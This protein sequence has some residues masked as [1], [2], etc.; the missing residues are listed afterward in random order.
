MVAVV[1]AACITTAP[2]VEA[3]LRLPTADDLRRGAQNVGS[4]AISDAVLWA[5][6]KTLGIKDPVAERQLTGAELNASAKAR[7]I[8]EHTYA[9]AQLTTYDPNNADVAKQLTK[10]YRGVVERIGR[11]KGVGKTD[12]AELASALLPFLRFLGE[13]RSDKPNTVVVLPGQVQRVTFQTYCMDHDAPAP[14]SDEYIH[15]VRRERLIPQYGATLYGSLMDYSARHPDQHGA[16][17]NLVWGMRHARAQAPFI[18][19]LAPDQVAMLN[20]VTSGGA[21]QYQQYLSKEM[22]TGRV[23]EIKSKIY[24]RAVAEIEHTIG[25]PLPPPSGAGLSVTDVNTALRYLEQATVT[26]GAVTP[27]SGFTLLANGVAARSVSGTIG[28]HSSQ[29]DILNDGCEPYTFNGEDYVGQSTRVTQRLALGGVVRGSSEDV[30]A[31]LLN[32]LGR[33]SLTQLDRKLRASTESFASVLH[34]VIQA[35][36]VSSGA[37]IPVTELASALA[38]VTRSNTPCASR[39]LCDIVKRIANLDV[40]K[41]DK[42]RLQQLSRQLLGAISTLAK[43]R[44]AFLREGKPIDVFPAAYFHVTAI[45]MDRIANGDFSYPIEKMQQ[46]VAFFDAYEYNRHAW[47]TGGTAEPHWQK[48]FDEARAGLSAG[49]DYQDA[50]QS[51]ITAHVDF[52]LPRALRDSFEHRFHQNIPIEQLGP[53]F[54]KTNDTLRQANGPTLDDWNRVS[55]D[56][57]VPFVVAGGKLWGDSRTNDVINRRENAWELAF[58]NGA[59]KTHDAPQPSI[60]PAALERIAT[61]VCGASPRK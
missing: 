55:P 58:G 57:T 18:R 30:R 5:A 52:D 23:D 8:F 39:D 6:A 34:E 54:T 21:D 29:L 38:F 47:E 42:Q 37:I 17:Q 24:R 13:N 48:H 60:D 49:Y 51:G 2:L 25:R 12:L 40:A 20:E 1:L 56:F 19:Q 16:V 50:L 44:E 36:L 35:A 43:Y 9:N 59:L 10:R 32:A 15:L 26:K 27:D 14:R 22:Q 7:S 3:Q 11:N 45:E 33:D 61:D 41:G 53:D 28:I 4:Q 31:V 46:L